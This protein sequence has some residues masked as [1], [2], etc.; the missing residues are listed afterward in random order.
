M[1]SNY[2]VG[3]TCSA[4]GDPHYRTFDGKAYDFMGNCKYVLAKDT[5]GSFTVLVKNKPCGD[6]QRSCTYTVTVMVK[7][8]HI[9]LLRGGLVQ[10][11]GKNIVLPYKNQ[12][13]SFHI[14]S[15]GLVNVLN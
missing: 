5:S 14:S 15:F 7:G 11:S 2:V 10:L 13:N 12:G 6:L 8:L 3:A 1:L 4:T 9:K